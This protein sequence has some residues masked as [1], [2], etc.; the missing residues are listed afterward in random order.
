M[1]STASTPAALLPAVRRQDAVLEAV[2]AWIE[3]EGLV[4]GTR[5]PSERT[6]MEA[7]RVGRSTLR[8]AISH[9][10]ALGMLEVRH[11]SGTY[12][13][14]AIGA[15]TVYLPLSIR[16]ERDALLQTLEIRRGLESEASALAAARASATELRTIEDRLD[17]MERVQHRDGTSGVEDLAFHESIYAASGNPLFGQLLSQM[18]SAFVAF[19]QHPFDR[20]DFG[21]RSFP[22]HRE[23]FDAIAARDAAAARERT[24]AIIDSVR[25]DIVEMSRQSTAGGAS[26]RGADALSA[27]RGR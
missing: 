23:L 13:R 18:R 8:E 4:P 9:L 3:R 27:E 7:L 24:L 26:G 25:E 10:V 21:R 14:R 16:F 6:L 5:L 1:P 15:D 12:L 2:A 11:G 22:F 20:V 19:W 17:E